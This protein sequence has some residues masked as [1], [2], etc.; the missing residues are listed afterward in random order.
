MRKIFF[1]FVTVACLC[2]STTDSAKASLVYD[3]ISGGITTGGSGFNNIFEVGDQV[4]LIGSARAVTSFEVV[5][6]D[7][8]STFTIHF[9]NTSNGA[10]GAQIWGSENIDGT[11]GQLISSYDPHDRGGD[12]LNYFQLFH[13]SVPNVV[14]PGEFV[15]T[16]EQPIIGGTGIVNNGYNIIGNS[17][18]YWVRDS[19]GWE[20]ISRGSG[21]GVFAFAAKIDASP[22]PVPG[23]ILLFGSGLVCLVGLRKIYQEPI[24]L[25]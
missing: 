16:V 14:V 10:I 7:V 9:Y 2:L 18:A 22:A 25:S 19:N 4:N 1:L 6:Q 8:P 13:V 3:S 15:W 24:I 17:N 21:T 11:S 20:R 12:G 5:M 23:A